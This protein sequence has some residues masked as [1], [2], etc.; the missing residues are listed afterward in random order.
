VQIPLQLTF[1]GMTQS[2]ALAAEVRLRAEKL[3]QLN[4]EPSPDS[5]A[6]T[7]QMVIHQ[8]FDE[9]ERLLEGRLGRQRAH[10]QD[11]APNE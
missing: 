3:Q 5:T 9:A 11:Q 6:E 2:D 4:H 1:R 10:R 7:A 8:A